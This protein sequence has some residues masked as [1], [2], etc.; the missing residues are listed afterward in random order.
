MWQLSI[1]S[2]RAIQIGIKLKG[3]LQE[4]MGQHSE[5]NLANDWLEDWRDENGSL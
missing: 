5:P 1:R 4:E 2:K 3:N